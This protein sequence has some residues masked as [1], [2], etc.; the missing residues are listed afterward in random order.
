[1]AHLLAGRR[2]EAGDV[3]DD[4]LGDLGG[5]ELGGALLGVAADLADHH[6][7]LG[8]GVGL[9]ELRTSMKSEPT[10]GSPPIPTIE[11]LPSPACFS[12]LPIW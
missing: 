10:I 3:G 6:D 12:S 7:Q 11:E 9:E 1:M 4:R 8:L 2:R 5:D